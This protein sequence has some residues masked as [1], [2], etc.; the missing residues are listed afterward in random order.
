MWS[1][2]W[3]V[4]RPAA[5]TAPAVLACLLPACRQ[6]G[7]PCIQ[8]HV[9]AV[10]GPR[11]PARR[12]HMSVSAPPPW[13]RQHSAAPGAVCFVHVSAG[14]RSV[15]HAGAGQGRQTGCVH[16]RQVRRCR[17]VRLLA[18]PASRAAARPLSLL[19]ADPQPLW[20]PHP[21]SP[22]CRLSVL[23]TLHLQELAVLGG[24][25]VGA[26]GSA[27]PAGSVAVGGDIAQTAVCMPL[28]CSPA[29]LGLCWV[30]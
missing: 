15:V 18:T 5:T 11:P 26:G 17:H 7:A 1:T 30:L 9:H 6:C 13:S 25:Q 19:P 24:R 2:R 21:A 28:C 22:G 23:H 12:R 10:A 29:A 4:R 20:P 16:V 8:R 3:R 27:V 14:C